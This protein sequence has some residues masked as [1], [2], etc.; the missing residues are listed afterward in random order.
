[1]NNTRPVVYCFAAFQQA[2][3][4]VWG[5]VHRVSLETADWMRHSGYVIVG[6]DP[7]DL[8]D[9]ATCCLLYTSPSP[10]D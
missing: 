4:R 1:M 2:D 3:G 9:L 10:R 7:H 6:P 8:I 5:T